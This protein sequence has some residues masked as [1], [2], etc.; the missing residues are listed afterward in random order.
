MR[1]PVG[2]L[3]AQAGSRRVA[4]GRFPKALERDLLNVEH[5]PS[6]PLLNF[7]LGEGLSDPFDSN[8]IR[9]S[10]ALE[11]FSSGLTNATT[12]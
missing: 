8:K 1:D 9:D 4:A 11:E 6:L 2:T 3:G 10:K 5:I 7:T 12:R